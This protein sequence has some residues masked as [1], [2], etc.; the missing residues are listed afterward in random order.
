MDDLKI[1]ID[2]FSAEDKKE[3]GYFIQRQKLKKGR[4]DFELFQLL[5]QKKRHKP[6]DL[7]AALYPQAPNAVAYYALRKRLMQHLTD[8]IVLKRMAGD[9]TAGST[10]MGW[11]SLAR[12]LFEAR[13]DRLGWN[14]LRK[15]E[16]LAAENE[17]FDLCNTVYNVQIEKADNEF[18]DELGEIIRKRDENKRCADEDE[19]AN[20]A[21]SI[22][23]QRLAAARTQGRDLQFNATIVEVLKTY[24]LTQAVSQRPALFYRLMS[25]ARSAVLAQKDFFSFAPFIISQYQLVSGKHGFSQAHQFYKVSLLYMIAHV[26]YRN[27]QFRLSNDYLAQLLAALQ[28][29]AKACS[30]AFYPKYIFLKTANDA[31]LGQ[32]NQ[33]IALMEHLLATQSGVLGQRDSLTARLGLSFLYFAREAYPKANKLLLQINPSHKWAE[34]IMGKE[35]VLR[36]CLG[37]IIIQYEFGNLDLALDKVKACHKIFAELLHQPVYNN[38]RAFLH[39]LEQLIL[40]PHEVTHKAFLKKVEDTLHFISLEREDL[41][42][43]SFYAWLKAKMVNRPYYEVLLELAGAK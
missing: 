16:K 18:A 37:E 5:Q 1:T 22:I 38:V 35:W 15:A 26:L 36:K 30:G 8:Y 42:A 13:A 23:L 33:S 39:L 4:K 43:I 2:T 41:Q 3:F 40:H 6:Q 28:G 11:V 14:M 25:I 10:I 31:F 29:Q 24:G 9:P 19:R 7:I 12:Y 20:I 27:R 17:Q 34:K 32:V 21:N